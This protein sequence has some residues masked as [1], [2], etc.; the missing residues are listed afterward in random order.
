MVQQSGSVLAGLQIR[1]WHNS[2]NDFNTATRIA[3][4]AFGVGG[5][6]VF[7]QI[8]RKFSIQSGQLFG[9]P[10][11]GSNVAGE[12]STANAALSIPF[13]PAAINYLFVSIQLNNATD[14]AILRNVNIT[15]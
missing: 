15:T 7:A 2:V 3:N 13:N 12:G 5:A 1:I 8:T 4:Y 11:L 14:T 10:A 6:D 9:F